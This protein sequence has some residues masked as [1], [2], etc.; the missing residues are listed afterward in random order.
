[1]KQGLAPLVDSKRPLLVQGAEARAFL[2]SRRI[3]AKRK[4]RPDEMYCFKCRTPR[5]PAVDMIDYRRDAFGGRLSGLC[6]ECSTLMF[7]RASAASVERL[8]GILDVQIIEGSPTPKR[9][10]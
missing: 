7:K 2:Q 5:R 8:R 1:M 9:A 6:S 4:C 3:E 10:A